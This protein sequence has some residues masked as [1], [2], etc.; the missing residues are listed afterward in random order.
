MNTDKKHKTPFGT[1]LGDDQQQW[2]IQMET[3]ESSIKGIPIVTRIHY[4]LHWPKVCECRRIGA[5]L[6][7]MMATC[8]QLP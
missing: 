8:L 4:L 6:M 7:P 3:N 1:E 2:C 5:I